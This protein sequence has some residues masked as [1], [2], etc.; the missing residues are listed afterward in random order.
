MKKLLKRLSLLVLSLALVMAATLPC[1]AADTAEAPTDAPVGTE[2]MAE[3]PDGDGAPG[4]MEDFAPPTLAEGDKV[5][6]EFDVEQ[7][8]MIIAIAFAVLSVIV[9]GLFL[10]RAVKNKSVR[11]VGSALLCVVLVALLIF[12]IAV[13]RFNVVINQFLSGQDS[14]DEISEAEAASKSL[15]QELESEG[16]VLLKNEGN[17]LPLAEKK[18]NLFGYGSSFSAYGGA[19]SGA[20]DESKNVSLKSGLEAAGF[21][22]NEDLSNFY[23][24]LEE[25]KDTGNVFNMMGNDFNIHEPAISEYGDLIDSAKAFS[26]TAIVV[27]SRAGGEGA[28]LPLDMAEYTGGTAGRHYLELTENEEAMLSMVEENFG[29][30]I[31]IVNSSHAMELGFLENDSI[32]AAIWIGCPGSTGMN[33]VGDVLSGKVNPSGRLVDTYAYDATSAPSYYNFGDFTYTNSKHLGGYSGNDESYYKFVD[34]A[35]GIYVGYRYYETR[36]IDNATGVCDE[37]AYQAAVQFPFGYGLSYTTFEQSMSDLTVA[38]GSISVDVTVTNTGDVAGKEVIQLYYTAPYTVGGIEKSHV[39]LA[40]FDKTDLL[41]PGASQT[42]TLTFAVDD[43]ASFDYLGAGCYVLDAGDYEIKLMA[44]AHDVIDSRIYT[45]DSTI[46]YSGDNSR[47]SDLIAAET[48]FAEYAGDVQYVSRADW[49]GTLPTQR[50]ADREASAELLADIADHSVAE[51]PDAEPIVIKDNGLTLA[52]MIGLDYDDPQWEKLLE[53]LSVEDMKKLIGTGGYQTLSIS[54]ISKP[55]TVDIDGPAGLN[56]LVSGVSGVQFCSEVVMASTWNQELVER[57]GQALGDE[58]VA[59][60][61]SGIY[62]PGANTHRSPFGGRNF[63]YFSE[64][65]LLAGKMAAAEIRGAMS[66]GCYCYVKHYALNDQDTN[67]SDLCTWANEQA[68]REIYLKPFEIAVKEGGTTAV[69]SSMN[70]IGSTQAG[71]C[72]SLCTTVL[73]DEWGFQGMVITDAYGFGMDISSGIAAGNDMALSTTG[74]TFTSDTN[75]NTV[76]QQ[77]R[78]ACHNI[79]YTVANSNA[80]DLIDTSVPWW[81]WLLSSVDAVALILIASGFVAATRKKKESAPVDQK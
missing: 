31:V 46:T 44:N 21:T 77:M 18:V 20:G 65:G 38:D 67:R 48:A 13:A 26:D 32:D 56:G 30:V 78:T 71:S 24:G 51:D 39:V 79:L 54:S 49:E 37:E 66:R 55:S 60:G 62:G 4:G 10:F 1:W 70:N 81:I 5:N 69:M 73:R 52:D 19:G 29:T 12:N 2:E 6:L 16:I 23:A 17:S 45:V 14:S 25:K 57:M 28:D 42:M 80:F 11:K 35:E 47:S 72:K 59:N 40:A 76:Q 36:Y 53:Q 8:T 33:A 63:E 64:D 50:T 75:S 58:A 34:Y 7:A 61:V 41:Q 74:A 15:T 3:M 22:V 68:I 9:L 27:F 43:M